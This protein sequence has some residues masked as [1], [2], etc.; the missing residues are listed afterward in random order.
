MKRINSSR[1]AAFGKDFLRAYGASEENA[2]IIVGH[3][4]D[5][6]LKGV[7]AQG[8][9]RLFEYANFM[10]S[11]KVDGKAVPVITVRAPGAF[12]V[13][14]N[15]GFGIVAMQKATDRM[16]DS[17]KEYPMSVAAVSSV[18]HTGR[19]GAFAEALAAHRCFGSVYGGGGHK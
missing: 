12:M 9:M 6:D 13:D 17:L 2:E 14:G 1:L 16:I 7:E 4:V 3:L 5:N 8:A 19:L 15:G 18:G 10:I 11:G